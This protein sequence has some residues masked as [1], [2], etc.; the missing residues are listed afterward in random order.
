M[1]FYK[2]ETEK[3]ELVARPVETSTVVKACLPHPH[4]LG[5]GWTGLEEVGV[6]AAEEQRGRLE[7]RSWEVEHRPR[8]FP[9]N[10]PSDE[11]QALG[12]THT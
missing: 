11:W 12:T 1:S 9:S 10:G 6:V 8:P 5:D 7:G 3:N 2:K 4:L